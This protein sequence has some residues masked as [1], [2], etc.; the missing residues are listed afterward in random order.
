MMEKL[1]GTSA[2]ILLAFKLFRFALSR[3]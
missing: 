3:H 2:F 1:P